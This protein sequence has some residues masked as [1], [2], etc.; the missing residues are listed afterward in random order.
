MQQASRSLSLVETP[1]EGSALPALFAPDPTAA[2]RFL[3]FFA[4]HLRNG[5]T[6]KAYAKAVVEFAD[7]CGQQGLGELG[8]IQPV[9]VAA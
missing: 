3:E 5:N 9:H 1:I 8:A 2:R 7:W 6:R 4:A